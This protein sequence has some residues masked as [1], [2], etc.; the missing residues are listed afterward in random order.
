MKSLVSI[1]SVVTTKKITLI[2]PEKLAFRME[3]F[4]KRTKKLKSL[5]IHLDEAIAENIEKLLDRAESELSMIEAE[6]NSQ[7]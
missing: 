7:P 6:N 3:D 5:D 2:V 4:E 1:R